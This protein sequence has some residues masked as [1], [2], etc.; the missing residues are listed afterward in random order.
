MHKPMILALAPMKD[1]TDLAFIQ[2]LNDL[3]SLPDYFITEYF[4][5]VGHHKKMDP[6]IMRSIDENPTSKPIYG[7]LVGNESEYLVRDALHLMQHSC[8]GVD[9]NMGCPA[10]LVCRRGA[11]G[12]MLRS[13]HNMDSV[14]GAL[15]DALPSGAFSVKCR[16]GY[17]TPDEFE[18][19]LPVIAKHA[20]DRV[21][22]HARTVK[23]GYRSSV[24]PEWVQWA[25]E[26]LS[27]PIIA[28][29]NI[30]DTATADAWIKHAR[31]AGLMIGRAA[32]RNPWLFAQL[33][34]HF[35]GQPITVRTYR[36]VLTYIRSLYEHTLSMQTHYVEEKHIHRL[37][38]YLVY[39]SR[40]L[41]ESFDH[42]MKRAKTAGEFLH[43]CESSLNQDVPLPM[44]PPEDTHLFA[45]FK[46]LLT[47]DCPCLREQIQV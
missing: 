8:A 20:P 21:C 23:E 16:L 22:I 17:E 40:G 27:C 24:H 26:T 36:D 29:G 33:R 34:E 47:E 37:K 15:R 41:P 35:Q 31:P 45:H 13:L 42:Q 5:T 18:R 11:G 19:I 6:Y 9:I 14:L 30:V 12:G 7:Q 4:R 28:N 32:L 25:A 39:T 46:A 1:V 44:T 2:T 38:K 43:L 10:P 3:N